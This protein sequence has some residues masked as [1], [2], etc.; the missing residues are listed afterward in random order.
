MEVGREMGT[1]ETE[2]RFGNESY[3]AAG[4]HGV[5]DV[6]LWGGGAQIGT[7]DVFVCMD[8]SNKMPQ[9]VGFKN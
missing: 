3:Y 9:T 8:T 7:A 1:F 2:T 6:F 4:K 5:S